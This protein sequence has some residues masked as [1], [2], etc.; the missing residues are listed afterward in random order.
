MSIRIEQV[1]KICQ[2]APVVNDVT[3]EI[4]GS[5]KPAL[6]AR[7]LTLAFVEPERDGA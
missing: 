1:T 3:I 5:K 4:E 7:W 2:G 6:T